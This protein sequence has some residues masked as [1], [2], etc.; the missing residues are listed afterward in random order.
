MTYEEYRDGMDFDGMGYRDFLQW[1]WRQVIKMQ[2]QGIPNTSWDSFKDMVKFFD[3]HIKTG[4][5]YLV[6][7]GQLKDWENYK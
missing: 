3:W 6:G 1:K 5:D 7:T 4:Y 2:L